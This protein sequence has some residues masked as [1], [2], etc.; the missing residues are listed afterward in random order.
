MSRNLDPHKWTPIEVE[1][2][3]GQVLCVVRRAGTWRCERWR[4][5]VE[6]IFITQGWRGHPPERKLLGGSIARGYAPSYKTAIRMCAA[7]AKEINEQERARERR[8]KKM[9]SSRHA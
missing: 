7:A 3:F 9:V 1:A 2:V 6:A 4:W 5:I 8:E